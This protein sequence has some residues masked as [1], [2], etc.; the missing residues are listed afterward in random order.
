[1]RGGEKLGQNDLPQLVDSG[2]ERAGG[3]HGR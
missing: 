3:G 1:L 2:F